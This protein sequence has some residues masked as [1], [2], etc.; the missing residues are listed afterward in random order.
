MADKTCN[1]HGSTVVVVVGLDEPE[2]MA[3][4]VEETM[5]GVVVVVAVT[6]AIVDVGAVE[7][8]DGGERS[9]REGGQWPAKWLAK[10]WE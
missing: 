6:V 3:M 2:A 5:P 8:A 7:P 9:S 1:G 10:E 4:R